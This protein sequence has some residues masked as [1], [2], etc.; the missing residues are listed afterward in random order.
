MTPAASVAT[1]YDLYTKTTAHLGESGWEAPPVDA[2]VLGVTPESCTLDDGS[3]GVTYDGGGLGPGHVDAVAAAEN[4]QS[5][6]K[7]L[8]L[9]ATVAKS[10]N[11]KND[12]ITVT[13]VDVKLNAQYVVNGDRAFISI[14]TTC[15]PGDSEKLGDAVE[16]HR[17]E[18]STTPTPTPAP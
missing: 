18:Q 6:W 1:L 15:V 9:E 8:G 14:V 3:E 16:K 13:G 7:S 4:V 5:Y 12:R 10:S 17:D 2:T 11:P